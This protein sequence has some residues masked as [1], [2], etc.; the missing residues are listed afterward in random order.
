MEL[1]SQVS[2]GSGGD[3]RRS[4]RPGGGQDIVAVCDAQMTRT[5]AGASGARRFGTGGWPSDQDIGVDDGRRAPHSQ[6]H[7]HGMAVGSSAAPQAQS[8]TI[9]GSRVVPTTAR[10]DAKVWAQLAP[11]PKAALIDAVRLYESSNIEGIWTSQT[12]G[13]PLVTLSAAATVSERLKLGTGIAL[14]F[15]RSPVETALSILDLDRISGGR[16]VLGLGS[17][18]ESLIAGVFGMPYG[19]PL[20]HMR[21]VVSIIRA[22]IAK[23]HTGELKRLEGDYYKL[24]LETFRTLAPPLRTDVPIYLPAV[25]EAACRQA[26]EIANGLLGHPLWCEQ[27]IRDEVVANVKQGLDKAGRRRDALDI[28]LMIFTAINE[29][30]QEAIDDTR[31]NIAFYSQSPQYHRYFEQIGFGREAKAIQEA[32]SQNDYVAM[33]AACTDAMVETI[34]VI[35]TP[36]EVRAGVARRV[37]YADS[38]TPCIPHFGLSAEKASYY[39]RRIAEVFY[40]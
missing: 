36:D 1:K 23:A 16:A 12:F 19:K 6:I 9:G 33:S 10:I 4:D 40:K 13:L 5:H 11:M 7:S 17:S 3:V 24:N 25:F 14:A 26:G 15:T 21:E 27:W 22:I 20:A 28:N 2:V 18:A 29:N 37:Q 39:T 30:R 34:A 31:A 38:F 35:G 8:K 32:H